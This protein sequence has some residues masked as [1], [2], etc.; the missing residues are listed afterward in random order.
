MVLE[1]RGGW[2]LQTREKMKAE[3]YIVTHL[4][5]FWPWRYSTMAVKKLNQKDSQTWGFGSKS[6]LCLISVCI[7]S[8]LHIF[9]AT[10]RIMILLYRYSLCRAASVTVETVTNRISIKLKGSKLM[11]VVPCS[12]THILA[13]SSKTAGVS[14]CLALCILQ[15]F[16]RSQKVW[17]RQKAAGLQKMNT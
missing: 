1:G 9:F 17:E 15:V 2:G 5:P 10:L 12:L 11:A 3:L 13:C 14:D 16:K 8:V 7:T 4:S 6:L